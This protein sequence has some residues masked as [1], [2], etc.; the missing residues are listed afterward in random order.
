MNEVTLV[1]ILYASLTILF[2]AF[3]EG[4]PKWRRFLKLA[5]VVSLTA[6]LAK[7]AGPFWAYGVVIAFGC[8]GLGVH[9]VWCRRNGIDILR[10][11]PRGKYFA[12]RGWKTDSR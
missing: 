9:V 12:L 11:E 3:E 6:L 8:V 7:Y 1:S 10:P 5:F 4:T 2:G